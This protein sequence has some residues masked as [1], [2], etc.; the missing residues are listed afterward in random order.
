MCDT[1]VVLEPDNEYTIPLMHPDDREKVD[2]LHKIAMRAK[3]DFETDYRIVY[4]FNRRHSRAFS[5]FRVP[6]ASANHS[7]RIK[8]IS[9][10]VSTRIGGPQVPAP[11]DV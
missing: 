1:A 11:L 10:R 2:E 6:I 7:N 5:K 8:T 9:G 4:P 3:L